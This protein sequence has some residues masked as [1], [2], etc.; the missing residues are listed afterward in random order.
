MASAEGARFV[1]M[2]FGSSTNYAEFTINYAGDQAWVR[3]AESAQ[4]EDVVGLLLRPVFPI[5]L[6][7][8]GITCLHASVVAVEGRA[9]GFM[10]LA[11]AG[12]SSM[13]AAF[14]RLGYPVLTDD[15]AAIHDAGDSFFVQPS[16]PS[17]SMWPNTA[18]SLVGSTDLPR[19]WRTAD[20]HSLDLALDSEGAE[21]RFETS[22]RP[23]GAVY[24]LGA[25]QPEA[26]QIRI[27]PIEPAR[28]LILLLANLATRS[29]ISKDHRI[30]SFELL[31]RMAGSVPMSEAYC[32][33]DITNLPR[34][35]EV[36]LRDLAG[37]RANR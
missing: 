15:A 26:T 24:W 35:C 37:L 17:I 19:L 16:F 11:G 3:W 27:E 9:V 23:I 31:S 10:G 30:R 33:D 20:K 13:A 2:R 36:I 4:F 21:F 7:L 32:P 12:K 22:P 29:Y 25:R 28:G 18:Q 14:G 5:V 1:Q 6:W 8:R 34:A